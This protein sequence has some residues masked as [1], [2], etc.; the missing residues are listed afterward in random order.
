[1]A[2]AY[3][4]VWQLIRPELQVL[5]TPREN[6]EASLLP[7]REKDLLSEAYLLGLPRERQLAWQ[8]G[9]RLLLLVGALK[10]EEA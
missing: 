8:R 9:Q 3:D 6:L 10:S 5:L 2:P 4:Q 7:S 1:M